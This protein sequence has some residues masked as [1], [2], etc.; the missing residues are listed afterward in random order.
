MA[1]IKEYNNNMNIV[2]ANVKQKKLF[3]IHTCKL[4]CM[5][6][7]KFKVGRYG[8]CY[9]RRFL[10]SRTKK[11]IFKKVAHKGYFGRKKGQHFQKTRKRNNTANQK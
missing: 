11:R 4:C 9:R 2:I 3:F 1:N 10:R 5:T 6:L 7:V 8:Q